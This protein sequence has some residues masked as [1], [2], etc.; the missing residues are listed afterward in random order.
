MDIAPRRQHPRPI[1]QQVAAGSRGNVLTIQTPQE[2]GEFVRGLGEA[3][4][5]VQCLLKLRLQVFRLTGLFPASSGVPE[6]VE[7]MGG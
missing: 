7:E 5:N 2:I 4:A 1:P 3:I 6:V